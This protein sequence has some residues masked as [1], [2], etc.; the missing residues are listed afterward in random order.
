[1]CLHAVE[2][3]LDAPHAEGVAKDAHSLA[4]A[5]GLA[6]EKGALAQDIR[7]EAWEDGSFVAPP[8]KA[9]GSWGVQRGVLAWALGCALQA[10]AWGSVA[11]SLRDLQ[12]HQ[13]GRAHV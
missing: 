8:R 3:A 13:I 7:H 1:M 2:V 6:L 12:P 11:P 5:F 4:E 9:S 10:W